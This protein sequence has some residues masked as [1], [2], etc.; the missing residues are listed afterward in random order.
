MNCWTWY[1]CKTGPIIIPVSL[2]GGQKQRVGIARAL[3]SDP[4]VLLSAMKPPAP[5]TRKPPN[6]SWHCSAILT[7]GCI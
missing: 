7:N 1:N 3:A 2:S 4:K 5:W 6:P